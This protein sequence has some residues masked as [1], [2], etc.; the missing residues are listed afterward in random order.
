MGSK[1]KYYIV[2]YEFNKKP[3]KWGFFITLYFK[4]IRNAKIAASLGNLTSYA[5]ERTGIVKRGKR[6]V[7]ATDKLKKLRNKIEGN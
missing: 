7:F 5:I 3:L 2:K 6:E 1:T 4:T